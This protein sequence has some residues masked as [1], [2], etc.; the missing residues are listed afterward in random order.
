MKN[1]KDIRRLEKKRNNLISRTS[2][3]FNVDHSQAEYILS[4]PYKN[5]F[6]INS[7]K[8]QSVKTMLDELSI[9]GWIGEQSEIL[10]TGFTIDQGWN[11]VRDSDMARNGY[12]YIQNAASWIPVLALDPRPDEL[13]LDMAAAPG[14]KASLIA[15]LTHN[16][17]NL[18]VNDN[19]KPRLNRMLRNFKTL[20]VK[21]E[22]ETLSTFSNLPKKLNMQFDKIILD[23][24]CSGEGLIDI[25]KPSTYQTWSVAHIKRLQSIQKNA[26]R[27]A[28]KLLRPGGTLVYSTCTMAPE[29]NE[30]VIDYLLKHEEDSRI[31]NIDLT[32]ANN[33][34]PVTEWN[35]RQLN[36]LISKTIRIMPADIYEGFFVAKLYKSAE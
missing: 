12:I 3:I 19:S 23:A 8:T 31:L 4:K 11:A 21:H 7:L 18:Y 9:L 25:N 13:I 28:W 5:S 15:D 22:S 2:D 17:S 6:R 35:N 16:K 32:L 14:G 26:V 10:D 36:P 30:M 27:S 20:N 33:S 34:K 1:S 24:P 29:E